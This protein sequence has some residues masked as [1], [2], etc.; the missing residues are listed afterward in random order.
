MSKYRFSKGEEVI[1]TDDLYD[2]MYD[3][4]DKDALEEWLN[5][6][7][8]KGCAFLEDIGAGTILRDLAEGYEKSHYRIIWNGAMDDY[9]SCS[10]EAVLED[11]NY[12][13]KA[14]FNGYLI[15]E[16]YED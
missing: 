15:S 11:L 7:E 6:I 4:A 10:Y 9:I 8:P 14:S 1:I 16:I 2:T 12:N 13:N 5:E 3:L